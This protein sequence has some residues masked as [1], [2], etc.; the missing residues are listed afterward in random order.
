MNISILLIGL[1]L[2]VVA[3]IVIQASFRFYM[4]TRGNAFVHSQGWS[5]EEIARRL[6]R[7]RLA[8]RWFTVLVCLLIAGF[9]VA[10]A[11]S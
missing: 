11:V 2:L 6:R 10:L 9:Y 3:P 1:L 5:E 8:V 7:A 4:A